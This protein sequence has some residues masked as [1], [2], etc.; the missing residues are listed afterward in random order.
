LALNCRIPDQS[1]NNQEIDNCDRV[2]ILQYSS[3]KLK[4][5]ILSAFLANGKLLHT[6]MREEFA[7]QGNFPEKAFKLFFERAPTV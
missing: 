1:K 6:V 3:G 7:S 4:H 2:A 5:N